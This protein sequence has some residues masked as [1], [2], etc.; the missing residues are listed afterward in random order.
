[1]DFPEFIFQGSHESKRRI[2][3]NGKIYSNNNIIY[4]GNINYNLFPQ[5]I[6]E[7]N[8]N[9]LIIDIESKRFNL[10]QEIGNVELVNVNVRREGPFEGQTKVDKHNHYLTK[11]ITKRTYGWICD[12]CKNSFKKNINSLYCSL[13]DFDLCSLEC[14]NINNEPNDRR[15]HFSPNF[16]IKTLQHK[17]HLTEMRILNG[18]NNIKCF[19]C[20]KNISENDFLFYCTKCDFRLCNKCKLIEKRGEIFQ[21]HCVWHEH[22]LTFC[23]TKGKKRCPICMG[24]NH[25]DCIKKLEMKFYEKNE[26][27]F[28]NDSDY[29]FICN[30]CGIEYSRNKDSFYCTACDF[31]ICMKCY[32]NHIFYIGRDTQNV[33][34][35]SLGNYRMKPILCKC[36]LENENNQNL[37]CKYCSINLNSHNM[38]Y[39][40]SNCNSNFCENCKDNHLIIFENNIIIYDG[41]VRNNLRNG[42]GIS[43]KND[44]SI[45]YDGEWV[46]NNFSLIKK[47]PH[48]HLKQKFIFFIHSQNYDLNWNNLNNN[49]ICNICNK[50]C[51]SYDKGYS[52]RECDIDICEECVIKIN[53]TKIM[54]EHKH[55]LEIIKSSLINKCNECNYRFNQN[56]VFFSCHSCYYDCC[57]F[58]FKKKNERYFNSTTL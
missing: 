42:Y 9:R 5:F 39:Y 18:R 51:T 27:D 55:N 2:I 1:M 7:S 15:P 36:Y 23:K 38:N 54:T 24:F 14:R 29:Y 45:E 56:I 25:Y 10:S 20:L 46:N 52:C 4:E 6:D 22:P 37:Q 3:G 31:Y 30:H 17:H 57:Q 43:Y 16:Q 26:V 44:N 49:I 33:V 35:N 34:N 32:K 58:C 53:K 13:C 50:E 48:I 21:F 47:L 12:L 40:C 41:K 8:N 28:M 19:S 11:C